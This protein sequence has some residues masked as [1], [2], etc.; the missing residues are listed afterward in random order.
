LVHRA[1]QTRRRS[2]VEGDDGPIGCL[3]GV[4][5]EAPAIVYSSFA[6]DE[7]ETEPLTAI[8]ARCARQ[9]AVR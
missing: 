8:L 9:L 6:R 2:A 7:S 1:S 3:E 4:G 5:C